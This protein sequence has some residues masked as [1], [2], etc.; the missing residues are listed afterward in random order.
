[1]FAGQLFVDQGTL[2]KWERGER[3]PA[4]AFATRVS[5]FLNADEATQA[6]DTARTA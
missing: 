5:G 1:V 6:G 3:Q 2:A 4:R